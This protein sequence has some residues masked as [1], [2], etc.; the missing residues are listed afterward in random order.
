MG[1][2]RWPLADALIDVILTRPKG[3][4]VDHLRTVIWG[5][6]CHRHRLCMDIQADEKCA[7]LR[8]G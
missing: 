5:D 6:L 1:G 2:L 4:E 8:H 3:P 7:R